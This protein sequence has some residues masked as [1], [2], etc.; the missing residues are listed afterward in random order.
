[1]EEKFQADRNNTIKKVFGMPCENNIEAKTDE[2]NAPCIQSTSPS[3]FYLS[4]CNNNRDDQVVP[5]IESDQTQ[6]QQRN[7]KRSR[8]FLVPSTGDAVRLLC[9]NI[10]RM[11]L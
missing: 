7:V 6:K 11:I 3:V 9:L 8:G 10:I 2:D 1:M 4:T 5:T